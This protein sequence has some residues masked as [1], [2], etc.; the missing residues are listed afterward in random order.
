MAD[1]CGYYNLTVNKNHKCDHEHK[2]LDVTIPFS[3]TINTTDL[4][5]NETN[6]E[7][8][9]SKYFDIKNS[10]FFYKLKF[11]K[12]FG[13]FIRGPPEWTKFLEHA[14]VCVRIR[15]LYKNNFLAKDS[16]FYWKNN[17]GSY[18]ISDFCMLEEMD[19]DSYINIIIMASE[20]FDDKLND[21]ARDPAH[22]KLTE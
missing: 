22:E 15:L 2:V 16:H 1:R 21:P 5:F 20:I 12:K 7:C 18:G 6:G 3:R 9:L 17:C 11:S 10:N 8:I 13:I 19:E 4:T 14:K